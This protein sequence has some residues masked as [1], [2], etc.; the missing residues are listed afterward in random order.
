MPSLCAMRRTASILVLVAGVIGL[1]GGCGGSSSTSDSA[2][3]KSADYAGASANPPKPV[4]PLE[5]ENSLGQ[6]VNIQDYRG[7][8]VLVTFLYDH[9]PDV[10]PLI[11]SNFHAAQNQMSAAERD[12]LQIIAVSVDPKGD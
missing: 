1:V 7:K 10:C 8:A 4:P 3:T 2:A 11:V 9:C 12:E 6:P 5:L